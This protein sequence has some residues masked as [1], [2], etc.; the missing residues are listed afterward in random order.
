MATNAY[1]SPESRILTPGFETDRPLCTSN[2]PG[3]TEYIK[4]GYTYTVADI[5]VFND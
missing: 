4:L 2:V 1:H 3:K 5:D